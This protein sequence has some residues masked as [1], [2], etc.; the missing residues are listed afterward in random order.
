MKRY[1]VVGTHLDVPSIICEE[2]H[3]IDQIGS[4]VGRE[5]TIIEHESLVFLRP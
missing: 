4:R 5:G 1:S 2:Y 3:K